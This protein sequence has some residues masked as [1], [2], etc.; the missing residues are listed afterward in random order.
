MKIF[1]KTIPAYDTIFDNTNNQ[2]FKVAVI[3]SIYNKENYLRKT[4][5]SLFE[6]TL[7]SSDFE[8]ILVDDCSSDNSLN[9]I[10]EYVE[11][12]SN[13]YFKVLKLEMNSGTPGAP[14]NIGMDEAN[15]E[16]LFIMDADDWL[17]KH[18]LKHLSDILDETKDD[19]VVGKTIEHRDTKKKVVAEQD[20]C[21]ELRSVQVKDVKNIFYHLG[22]RA[23]MFKTS[24]VKDNG[25]FFPEMTYG[26]DK[27]FFID[28]LCNCKKISTTKKVIYHL[29]RLSENKS[30]ITMTNAFSKA[31]NNFL[32]LR[33]VL[34]ELET[35]EITKQLIISRILEFDYISRLI[36]TK[37]FINSDDIKPFKELFNKIITT[38]K[39]YNYDLEGLFQRDFHLLLFELIR[40]NKWRTLKKVVKWD[41]N[42]DNKKIIYKN[43]FLLGNY[44]AYYDIPIKNVR[45][46]E[47]MLKTELVE[48]KGDEVVIKA[49]GSKL[50]TIKC[51]ELRKR[52]NL[53]TKY[54]FKPFKV[55]GNKYYF[56]LD[57]EITKT[58]KYSVFIIYDTYR[59][60]N[61]HVDN[62][63][64]ASPFY[65]TIKNNLG[66]HL[67]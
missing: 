5:D 60:V 15:S 22:P 65:Q 2:K 53:V 49:Y 10:E 29:N 52:S 9:I 28:V 26:E 62:A 13:Y 16:Y 7:D 51:L 34:E 59:K 50:K 12:Y 47:I 18:A 41:K 44:K 24:I 35:D 19:Y 57:K 42:E 11:K 38:L 39:S 21:A 46:V 45:K 8:I 30:L 25:L 64:L 31:E 67:K 27:K 58:G 48:I 23:R 17:N 1:N 54:Q 32:V 20:S 3:I 56:K 55:R 43:N 4:L 40:D 66:Y 61:V 6:Q 14:R 33:Y 37:L 36:D 63:E